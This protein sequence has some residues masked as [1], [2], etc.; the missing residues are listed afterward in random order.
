VNIKKLSGGIMAMLR[1][2]PDRIRNKIEQITTPSI[3]VACV[4][5]LT[6]EKINETKLNLVG[7]IIDGEKLSLA[8]DDFIPDE[9]FGTVSNRNSN[10]IEISHKEKPK[11]KKSIYLG[12]RPNFGD[13]SK[14]SFSLWQTRDVYQKSFI[15]PKGL[16]IRVEIHD[17]NKSKKS[18]KVTFTIDTPL[19]ISSVTF[20]ED[21]LF[22]LSLLNEVTR[23]YNVFSSETTPEQ[24]ASARIV[25]WEFFPPGERDISSI[26]TYKMTHSN[27][28]SENDKTIL[29]RALVIEKLKPKQFI[30]GSEI[31]NDY[32]GAQFHENLIVFENIRYGN[33]TYILYDD[34]EEISKLSRTEILNSDNNFDRI[35]H[36]SGWEK[37]LKETLKYRL[38]QL[39]RKYY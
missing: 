29:N 10:G 19:D 33:A 38:R 27:S 6:E 7:F 23:K 22:S 18:W 3:V 5:D 1:K 32:Y 39:N 37:T 31:S 11:V 17:Y 9:N 14:G 2:I 24:I 34:W 12:D 35:I 25:S 26:I 36:D 8:H 15:Q 13:W 20:E 28:N 16:S 21:L 4:Q 30:F